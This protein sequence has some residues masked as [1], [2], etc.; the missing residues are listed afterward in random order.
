M[1]YLKNKEPADTP[2]NTYN[3]QWIFVVSLRVKLP[4]PPTWN[5]DP[6]VSASLLGKTYS[7]FTPLNIPHLYLFGCHALLKAWRE[8][9]SL[10]KGAESALTCPM[11][12]SDESDDPKPIVSEGLHPLI[13]E[14][15][16]LSIIIWFTCIFL[17]LVCMI[18]M[19]II[20]VIY[21][22]STEY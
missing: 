18:N 20:S 8:I 19:Y 1:K 14:D 10:I 22:S 15:T 3:L 12:I 16:I 6:L 21:I 11:R 4:I 17:I 2:H 7:R 13:H 5:Q 9:K